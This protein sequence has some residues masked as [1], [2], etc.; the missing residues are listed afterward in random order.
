MFPRSLS[1]IKDSS[2]KD[3]VHQLGE[4]VLVRVSQNLLF[5]NMLK[6]DRQEIQAFRKSMPRLVLPTISS[7]ITLSTEP[8]SFLPGKGRASSRGNGADADTLGLSLLLSRSYVL[9]VTEIFRSLPRHLNDRSELAI[10]IDGL[11]QILFVHGEDIGIV[12]H[13]LIGELLLAYM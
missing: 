10:L 9:L 7:T 8:R 1:D 11:N 12:A 6:R 3:A 4:V 13:V 5:A 2:G